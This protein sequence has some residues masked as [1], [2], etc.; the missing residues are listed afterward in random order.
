M[1]TEV[2]TVIN[3]Y[4]YIYIY[5]FQCQSKK[6]H[7]PKTLGNDMIY[8]IMIYTSYDIYS[9]MISIYIYIIPI[10]DIIYICDCVAVIIPNNTITYITQKS[11]SK[12]YS[13][14]NF[15]KAILKI[16]YILT[17]K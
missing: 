17:H 1:H 14:S 12:E 11:T 4:I 10:Y 2:V 16:D 3:I 7:K 13:F 5:I 15:S 6:I 8:D 9:I